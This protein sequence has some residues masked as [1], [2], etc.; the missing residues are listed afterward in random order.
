[1]SDAQRL[2]WEREYLARPAR[3]GWRESEAAV[4]A[5]A[6]FAAGGSRLVVDLGCGNGRDALAFAACGLRMV[7]LD[8]SASAVAALR[9][10]AVAGGLAERIDARTHDVR[11]AL[12]LPDASV[13]GVFAHMLHCMAL[14][15][16][17]VDGL[18]RETY[19][20][21]RPGGVSIFSVR[22]DRDPD[23]T[24]GAALP[25]GLRDVDGDVIRFFSRGDAERAVGAFDA[26]TFDEFE[27]GSLPKRLY[28][29]TA[30]K[31]ALSAP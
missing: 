31:P 27:E 28:L 24:L 11:E 10:R 22:N 23:C 9:R 3:F 19:R 15:E 5:R 26:P 12:P 18:L 16:D 4:R 25:E 17:E 30:R 8:Y 13:D 2:H 7:A 6:I 20:V 14:R 1:L 29:V 21:L